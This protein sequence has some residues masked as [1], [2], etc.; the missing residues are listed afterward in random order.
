MNLPGIRRE[1]RILQSNLF[2]GG[3]FRLGGRFVFR[4]GSPRFVDDWNTKSRVALWTFTRPALQTGRPMKVMSV[5]TEEL[6]LPL[7]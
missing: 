6:N 3:D 2:L 5:R 4:V 7:F 1:R